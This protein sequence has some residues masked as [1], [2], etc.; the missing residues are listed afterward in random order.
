MLSARFNS[1][2]CGAQRDN[3][4]MA[5]QHTAPIEHPAGTY[6]AVFERAE[7]GTWSGHVPDLPGIL[8]MGYTLDEA[9]ASVQEAIRYWI[10]DMRERNE[11]IP[12]PSKVITILRQ[13]T[14]E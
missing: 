11:P 5:E 12:T 1:A 6:T 9:K 2:E 3:E 8:G 14:D 7:E 13:A 4:D 10:E